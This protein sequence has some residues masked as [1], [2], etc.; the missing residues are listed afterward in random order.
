M[1]VSRDVEWW[2]RRSSGDGGVG[3][4]VCGGVAASS[5]SYGGFATMFGF[6]LNFCFDFCLGLS[7][8]RSTMIVCLCVKMK[9]WC[10]CECVHF[11]F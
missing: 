1:V 2:Q 6:K 4:V 7:A 8:I 9:V 11:N 3:V 10:M 5:L